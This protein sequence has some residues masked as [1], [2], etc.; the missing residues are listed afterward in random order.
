MVMHNNPLDIRKILFSVYF[1][2]LNTLSRK[3]PFILYIGI[4]AL[5]FYN[6][7]TCSANWSLNALFIYYS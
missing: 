3:G 6:I 2:I 7:V 4:Q 5:F 1:V